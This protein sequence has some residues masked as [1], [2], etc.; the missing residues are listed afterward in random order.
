ML[1][2]CRHVGTR[3]IAELGDETYYDLKNI[4]FAVE[5]YTVIDKIIYVGYDV[6]ATNPIKGQFWKYSRAPSAYASVETIVE[7][8]YALHLDLRWR[9]FVV[10]KELCHALEND[11]GT[12]S[13]STRSIDRILSRFAL[14]SARKPIQGSFPAFDAEALAELG[15]LELIC[16]LVVR[17]KLSGSAPP[18]ALS[19]DYGIPEE[20]ADIAFDP[21]Q[22]EIAES[23]F[24]DYC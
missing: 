22:I 24:E 8:R 7:V 11:E 15:A 6:P 4:I 10:C 13:A 21:E 3:L 16:P 18:S 23:I 17:K 1:T 9:R 19:L 12:H 14:Y 5:A 2:I 20:Y